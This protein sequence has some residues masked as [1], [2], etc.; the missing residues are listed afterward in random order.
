MRR[1]V[2]ASGGF[3]GLAWLIAGAKRAFA[4]GYNGLGIGVAGRDP[5]SQ[6]RSWNEERLV[7]T[8]TLQEAKEQ[9][10]QAIDIV[11]LVGSY[12]PL[13]R[14]GARYVARCPWH[15]DS[16]PSLQVNQERQ[17]WKCWVCNL[18]GDVFSFLMQQEGVEFREA[19]EMLAE[20]AG[21]SLRAAAKVPRRQGD[22]SD[23]QTLFEALSWAERL[24][25]ECLEQSS[26]ALSARDYLM[27]RG[28][29]EISRQRFQLGFS[30]DSW[31]WLLDRA[32]ST[33]FSPAVLQAAGLVGRSESSGNYYDFFKGRV[34]FPIH[35]SQGR[36]IGFGGRV[37]PQSAPQNTGKYI[38]TRETKLFSKSE[39]VYG[40]DL[41]R[42]SITKLREVVVVEG[43]TDVIMAHQHG[44]RNVVAVLGT[45]LGPRH[46]RLLKRYADTIIL[47]LDGDEAGQ[48]RTNEVLELFVA[49]EVDLRVLTLPE[50]D[51][52]CDFVRS[53]G[54]EAFRAR[55]STAP[56]ALA[57]AAETQLRGLDL[58]R[59]THR[60]HQA[61]EHLLGMIAKAPQLTAATSGG[62]LLREQQMLARLARDFQLDVQTL[63]TR[64]IELRHE[65]AVR[66]PSPLVPEPPRPN[67]RLAPLD[68]FEE[69]L[70]QL[71]VRHPELTDVVLAELAVEHLTGATAQLLYHAFVRCAERGEAID[72]NQVLAEVDEPALKS[73]LVDLDEKAQEKEPFAETT[74]PDRLRAVLNALQ[75]RRNQPRRRELLAGLEKGRYD[76]QQEIEVLT[77]LIE[78]ERRRQ[79]IPAPTDG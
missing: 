46:I 67:P 20:R 57:H 32:R 56:D 65:Q 8:L 29:D 55:L 58:L 23:K 31:Q 40:L 75:E 34:L 76:A 61:L 63:R 17:S 36:T 68:R 52:P 38:N 53:A 13:S 28:I 60:A 27:T 49:S 72:F 15:D 43:Y 25:R 18:G 42:E 16:R 12:L 48:R 6:R 51:D 70:L 78:M 71:L 33:S 10:R 50:G 37:L 79:G 21:I 74:P 64:I 3:V 69:E 30:P 11:E 2:K 45:A 4:S 47:V 7:S 54:P 14:Q 62:R 19:L 77:Q 39:H 41:A 5:L 1:F 44:V 59:D 9:I 24:F 22:P 35:D 73:L 26:L 66:T